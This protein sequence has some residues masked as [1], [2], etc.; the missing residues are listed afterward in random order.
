M[1][2]PARL[3]WRRHRW[4]CPVGSWTGQD[5]RI[6][7]SRLVLT[8]RAGRWVT[9]QVGWYGRAVAEVGDELDCD[10]RSVNEAVV[11][12]GTPLVEDPDR[13]GETMAVGLDEV[14][15]ARRGRW[16]TQ[17]WSTS[18]TD[19]AR[20][21]LLDVIP[22]RSAAGACAWFAGRPAGVARCD[23][24]GGAGSVGAVGVDL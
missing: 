12:Y 19:V 4:R 18:I 2:R 3:V 17:A 16:R 14:L 1:L 11:A 15:F 21:R 5:P 7:A 8:D 20:G 23:P 13:I 10:W 22:G 9:A 6:A 24:L